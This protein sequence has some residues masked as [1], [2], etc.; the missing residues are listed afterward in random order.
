[1]RYED[2]ILNDPRPIGPGDTQ[3]MSAIRELL[4]CRA[5]INDHKIN[6]RLLH[7]LVFKYSELEKKLQTLN[8]ELIVKQNR[9]EK[10]LSAA[11]NIQQSLLPKRLDSLKGLEV[12]W[13]FKPCEKIGGD[14]FNLIQLD[15]EHWAIYII[16]VAGHGV[17]AAM[18]AVSVFQYLQ[19][20]SQSLMMS[21]DDKL[22]TQR[23]RRPAQV[24]EF[25]DQA[26]TF[27]RFDNFFTMNY[28]IVNV[29]TGQLTSSSAGHPPPI[30]LRKDGTLQLLKKGGRPLGT[31]D[32]LLSDDE[33]IVYEEEQEQL[34]SGDKLIFY[35]D[36]VTEYQNAKGEFYGNGRFF[37]RLKELKDQPVDRLV[38]TVFKSLMIFGNNAEPKDDVSL[39]GIELKT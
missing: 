36:G 34:C 10:D 17:P 16:D 20:H 23:V 13:K 26:F 12:A 32:L 3:R 11:A 38:E 5:R 37:S 39:L 22:K 6:N 33:P 14:I 2:D 35:T 9:I 31:I 8:R 27:E 28:V 21:S 18:V 25:L 29:K 30:I 7:E 15:N 4:E 24:L 19:P 1:M